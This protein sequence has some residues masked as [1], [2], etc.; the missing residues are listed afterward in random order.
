MTRRT[1][2][3]LLCTSWLLPAI[4]WAGTIHVNNITGD[5]RAS[6]SSPDLR[7][8][9]DGPVATI[10]RA[11]EL[12]DGGDE[13]V[14]ANT[15]EPYHESVILDRPKLSGQ[16]RY[17]FLIEGQGAQLRGARPL[18]SDVWRR[19]GEGV[20]R[21]QPY[22]KGHY[23]LVVNG[24]PA[25]EVRVDRGSGKIPPLAPLEWCAVGGY[26]Y[27]RVEPGRYIDQYAIEGPW[28]DIGLGIHNLSNVTV[29]NLNVELFRLDGIHVSGNSRN[30]RIENIR[31]TGSGR[32]G[33]V[34]AGTSDV[35]AAG[36]DL[37]GNRISEQLLLQ[38]AR[39]QGMP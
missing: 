18:D 14:I 5:D 1:L 38:R 32:A 8:L 23:Q 24:S 4:S 27:F 29:R 35:H 31:S 17:P 3:W 33:L 30:I 2:R 15:G 9:V 21:Y 39:L 28:F 7:S 37:S 26:V 25:R 19:V 13:I 11:L 10:G 36:L 16:E 6:G 12:A 20:Y 22:R 34:V